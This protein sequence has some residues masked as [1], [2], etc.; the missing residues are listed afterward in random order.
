[1]Y[2]QNPV[3]VRNTTIVGNAAGEGETASYGGAVFAGND[4][5]KKFSMV[6][7]IITGNTTAG[8]TK[9]L[10]LNYTGG[11]DY[12]FFDIEADKV[13][14]G[15]WQLPQVT[16][17]ASE[18]DGVVTVTM[19]NTSADR[20]VSVELCGVKAQKVIGRILKGEMNQYNDFGETNLAVESFDGFSVKDGVVTVE[21]PACCVAEIRIF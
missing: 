4:S 6:N 3:V 16:A 8:A 9:T 10:D 21:L 18:K 15:D 17:S 19:A 14:A 1:M 11:V 7:C 13:G 2:Q 5:G 12:C 20:A